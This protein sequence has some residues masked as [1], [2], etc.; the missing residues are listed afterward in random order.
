VRTI[1]IEHEMRPADGKRVRRV[2]M[3]LDHL[4]TATVVPS[5]GFGWLVLRM[6]TPADVNTIDI[7]CEST[8]MAERCYRLLVEAIGR[9]WPF[10]SL[11]TF[12][13]DGR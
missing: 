8:A 9:G 13:G 10:V 4:V 3:N 12:P 5:P 6:N 7:A 2:L 1:E 11:P